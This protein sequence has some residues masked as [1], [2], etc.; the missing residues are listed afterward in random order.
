MCH[1]ETNFTTVQF[2][3]FKMV[4]R[5]DVGEPRLFTSEKLLSSEFLESFVLLKEGGFDI[6]KAIVKVSKIHR[7]EMLDFWR[8]NYDIEEA[9]K[10]AKENNEKIPEGFHPL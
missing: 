5:D 3:N 1:S 7:N 6:L 10:F 4:I 2:D 9:L 8:L